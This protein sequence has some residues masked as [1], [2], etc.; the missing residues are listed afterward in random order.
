[1]L[2]ILAII[3]LI[4]FIG[5]NVFISRQKQRR[6]RRHERP[7]PIVDPHTM[8]IVER[9]WIDVAEAH[10]LTV[11]PA[12]S[13]GMRGDVN[14][15]PCELELGEASD[16]IETVARAHRIPEVTRRLEVVPRDLGHRLL[17]A[18]GKKHV[19]TGDASFDEAF[20]VSSDEASVAAKVLDDTTRDTLVVLRARGPKLTDDGSTIEL[21]LA[22]AEMVHEN[23]EA[24]FALLTHVASVA[25]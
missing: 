14:G 4:S 6:L 16:G 12:G 5:V 11:D 13:L 1:M 18:L 15:V 10:G 19:E 2:P 20:L 8:A 3:A 25:P 21:T 23:L 22:G 24:I 17:G 9:V 7:V